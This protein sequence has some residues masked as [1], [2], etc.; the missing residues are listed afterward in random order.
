M[1]GVG[2]FLVAALGGASGAFLTWVIL[3][4][5]RASGTADEAAEAYEAGYAAGYDAGGFRHEQ[6][7]GAAK[8]RAR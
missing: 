8:E 6:A 2:T 5:C 4:L 1:S 7:Q 3:A